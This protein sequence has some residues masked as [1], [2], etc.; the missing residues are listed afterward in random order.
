MFFRVSASY[1]RGSMANF[2][3]G[4]ARFGRMIPIQ[5]NASLPREAENV[6]YSL[7]HLVYS[8]CSDPKLDLYNLAALCRSMTVPTTM[9][10]NCS[11][12]DPRHR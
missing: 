5:E 10:A 3:V 6:A 9:Q 12:V 11:T 7:Y 4:G 2:G 1:L 8:Y